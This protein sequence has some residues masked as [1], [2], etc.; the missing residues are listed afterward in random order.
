VYRV[1]VQVTA[2]VS[3]SY[4]Q[5]VAGLDDASRGR[6]TLGVFLLCQRAWDAAFAAGREAGRGEREPVRQEGRLVQALV[7]L[8]DDMAKARDA[9]YQEQSKW[10]TGYVAKVVQAE[11]D[12]RGQ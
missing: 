10:V 8:S 3:E 2:P 11:F 5:W 4:G 1:R 12:R 7:Q 9:F 6:L